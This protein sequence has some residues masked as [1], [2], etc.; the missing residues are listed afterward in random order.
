DQL[1]VSFGEDMNVVDERFDLPGGKAV[2]DEIHDLVGQWNAL[3]A[4]NA[5]SAAIHALSERILN[6]LDMLVELTAD[7]SFV[8]RR[9][10]VDTMTQFSYVTICATLLGLL[11]SAGILLMLA[12]RIVRPLRDAASVADRIAG[13]EL[14]TPIPEGGPDETGALLRSMTVMQDSIRVMVEREKAQ[15][16]SAQTRLAEALE[17]A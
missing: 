9:Q 2:V 5:D 14:E 3:R 7:N 1:S 4:G 8:A 16:R 11:L 10:V 6:R 17:N 15:R 12:R 13:G